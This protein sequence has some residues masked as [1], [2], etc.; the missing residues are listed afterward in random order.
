MAKGV[1]IGLVVIVGVWHLGLDTLLVLRYW[2]LYE[3]RAAATGSWLALAVIQTAGS[4][5]L[6]P[7]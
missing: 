4:I 2:P 7:R 3:P 1:N 5:L 6:H